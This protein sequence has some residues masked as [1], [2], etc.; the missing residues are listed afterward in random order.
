[1]YTQVMAEKE[2][3]IDLR[4]EVAMSIQLGR[5]EMIREVGERAIPNLLAPKNPSLD[6]PSLEIVA[7]GI[8]QVN[9][10]LIREAAGAPSPG[11]PGK[12]A[13]IPELSLDGLKNF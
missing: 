7:N 13:E 9:D 6:I 11:K 1:M 8:T 2:S 5:L 3:L 4:D 12:P 10:D